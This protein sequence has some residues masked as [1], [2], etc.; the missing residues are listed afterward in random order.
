M[1]TEIIEFYPNEDYDI[2]EHFYSDS[3]DG[4]IAGSTGIQQ[5]IKDKQYNSDI[6]S[7]TQQDL[8]KNS[9]DIQQKDLTSEIGNE[10]GNN[11]IA[12][13]TAD[14][15]LRNTL[16][17]LYNNES[18]RAILETKDTIYDEYDIAD[19]ESIK[20]DEN[21]KE[22][23]RDMERNKNNINKSRDIKIFNLM[24][25]SALRTSKQKK[26]DHQILNDIKLCLWF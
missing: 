7:K 10:I 24:K 13:A 11:K 18:E 9:S 5:S 8:S 2:N 26:E 15:E 23:Q 16:Q 12:S 14:G 17:R 21:I 20:E 6:I 22:D 1:K 19:E 3:K 25:A 4:S